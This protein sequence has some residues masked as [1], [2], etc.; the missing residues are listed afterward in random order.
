[1]TP[2]DEERSSGKRFERVL[3]LGAS[4]LLGGALVTELARRGIACFAPTRREMDLAETGAI[5]RALEAAAPD[6]VLNAAAFT[7]VT[8][9]ETPECRDIVLR[10]NRD[11]PSALSRACG[12]AGVPFVLFSTDYVFDGSRHV[13]YVEEDPPAPLQVYGLSKLEAER[14][15]LEAHPRALIVRTST[16]FGPGRHRR[17]TFV[18]TVLRMARQMPVVGIVESPVAS[19]TYTPDLAAAALDLLEAG[20][21]GVVHAVNEGAASR[22]EL[23]RAVV[24]GAGLSGIVEVRVQ[25]EPPGG[26]L[27]PRFSALS[28][29][30]F[31][32]IA[33]RPLRAWRDALSEYL[34]IPRP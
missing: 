27:W 13:P 12:D 30:R 10:V 19:P 17:P 1:M 24:E 32:R 21:T 23:A 22:L 33:G 9:A 3:V 31:A 20:A 34:E 2:G 28:G 26:A 5:G 15:V 11:A 14:A 18:D 16:L 8:R 25:P 6:A 7:D 29:A 4:G